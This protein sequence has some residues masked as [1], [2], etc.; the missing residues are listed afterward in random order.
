LAIRYLANREKVSEI[1]D[2]KSSG[3]EVAYCKDSLLLLRYN[4][5]EGKKTLETVPCLIKLF[6][7]IK[8]PHKNKIIIFTF[9]LSKSSG[10][11]RRHPL[12][13]QCCAGGR[14]GVA[15]FS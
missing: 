5:G 10:L 7:K 14:V 12:P 15:L 4:A 9:V 2:L 6:F 13:S 8:M 11:Q 3:I 1:A